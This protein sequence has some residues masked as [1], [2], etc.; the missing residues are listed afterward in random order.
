MVP[1]LTEAV[2]VAV[3][4]T[5][6]GSRAAVP[7]GVAS[8]RPPHH[9]VFHALTLRASGLHFARGLGLVRAAV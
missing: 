4:A 2:H 5:R 3:R 7:S 6:R 1:G 9:E 8:S